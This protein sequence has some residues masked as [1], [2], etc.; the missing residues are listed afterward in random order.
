MT[1]EE[2]H[3]E[4]DLPNP[5]RTP[6]NEVGGLAVFEGVMMRS[7]TGFALA[8]RRRDGAI[9]VR[10]IP[11]SSILQKRK[12]FALPIL[13]G[14]AALGEMMFIGTRAL[15]Y[16]SAYLDGEK[17][18]EL[19]QK[20]LGILLGLSL[21][22]MAVV[23]VLLPDL[24]TSYFFHKPFFESLLS[25]NQNG[26]Y[27]EADY[28]IIANLVSGTIRLG[29]LILYIVCISF[30]KDI[31]R[32][33]QYHGAEHKSVMALEEGRDVTVARARVH[34]TL[35]PRCGTTLLATLVLVTV[36][37]FAVIDGLLAGQ[38][39]GFPDWPL[40]WRKFVQ[41]LA[42]LIFL[43]VV[44]GICFELMKY[45]N[46]N[47]GKKWC[48][49][50]LWPGITLQRLTTRQPTDHQ[51]EVAIV[52]LLAALAIPRGEKQVKSYTV[53]GLE[54]D[55]SAPGYVERSPARVKE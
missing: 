1:S 37:A 20:R 48:R 53:R 8:M 52:A 23:F 24:L 25:L 3:Y 41:L 45:C 47:W 34:D 31:R 5:S 17:Q 10:Q 38:I 33:F 11:Y 49:A 32:V 54:D 6:R 14:A 4:G 40:F 27:T 7:R 51:L 13:R 9:R 30:N 28:P 36:V 43:P 26:G 29:L 21:L 22:M 2:M 42:H 16:S 12:A 35:H 18:E 44:I 39:S 15:N 55:E 50:I 46:R 19:D